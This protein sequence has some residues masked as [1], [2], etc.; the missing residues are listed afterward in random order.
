MRAA[1]FRLWSRH[2]LF[3]GDTAHN[4]KA[5]TLKTALLRLTGRTEE[6]A[7]FAAETLG[8]DSL[9]Q[10]AYYELYILGKG[11]D[12]SIDEAV[13]AAGFRL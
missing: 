11:G 6:A 1:G 9:D 12:G 5:R 13:R 3:Q 8:I 2:L 4:L 7:A 10:G